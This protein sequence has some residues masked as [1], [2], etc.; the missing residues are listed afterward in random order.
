MRVKKLL[1]LIMVMVMVLSSCTKAEEASKGPVTVATMIDSEGAV[2][3]NVLLLLLEENGFEAVDKVGLGTPD[4]L[5]KALMAAEVD[6]VIDYTGSGQYYG[7]VAE[8]SVWS[9]PTL[10]YEA[11]RDFDKETNNLVWLTPA[12]ANNT[13]M[14]AVKKSF[15]DENGLKTMAD[16]ATYVNDGNAVK[17]ICSSSF[18]ENTL[19]LLGY[20]ETYGFEL[21]ADNLIVLSHGNTA[22]MLKALNDGTNDVNVSLVYGTDGSLAEM[23]MVILEDPENVPPVY[24]PTPIIRG[25]LTEEYPELNDIF[26]ETFESLDVETL[27][28]L[29]AKVAFSGEDAREVAKTYLEEKGLLGD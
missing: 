8:P 17:L 19:G 3:G 18:A 23:D 25:E 29:N 4:I 14:L 22:E 15:A 12:Q 27:Q 6:L 9:D 2:L 21:T 13:E 26:T 7:A 11:T 5:R 28:M 20:Q 1:I 16:F 24:L 10:G